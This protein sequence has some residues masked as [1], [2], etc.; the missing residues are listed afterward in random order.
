MHVDEDISCHRIQT[1]TRLKVY[2]EQKFSVYLD[3][4][5]S[6]LIKTANWLIHMLT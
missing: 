1:W 4:V 2:N 3:L 5:Y 6:Y